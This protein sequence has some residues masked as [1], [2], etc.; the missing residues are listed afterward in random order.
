MRPSYRKFYFNDDTEYHVDVIDTWNMTID[1]WD[2]KKG[3]FK[4]ELPRRQYMAIRMS[5]A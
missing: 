2:V 4:I 1:E 3:H 5:F